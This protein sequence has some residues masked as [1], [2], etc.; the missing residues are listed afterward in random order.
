M[1]NCI[2]CNYLQNYQVYQ[3]ESDSWQHC[4]EYVFVCSLCFSSRDTNDYCVMNS[5]STLSHREKDSTFEKLTPSQMNY[6]VMSMVKCFKGAFVAC[7]CVTLLSLVIISSFKHR[8]L[9]C[10]YLVNVGYLH[11]QVSNKQKWKTQ[12]HLSSQGVGY[13][14][15]TPTGTNINWRLC[16]IVPL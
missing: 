14:V 5:S 6:S 11:L 15:W 8:W 3:R 13:G 7:V 4:K 16:K 1:I 12:V 9:I 10:L 2:L